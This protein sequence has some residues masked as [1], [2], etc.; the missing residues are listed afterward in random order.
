[1]QQYQPNMNETGG[2]TPAP[3]KKRSLRWNAN[4]LGGIMLGNI[5]VNGVITGVIM[6]VMLFMNWD[7]SQGLSFDTQ[8]SA[9]TLIILS[10]IGSFAGNG[11]LMGIVYLIRRK[12][13]NVTFNRGNIVKILPLCALLLLAVNLMVSSTDYAIT[14]LLDFDVSGDVSA[15]LGDGSFLTML[16]CVGIAAP[17]IE[18]FAFR[19]VIFSLFREYGFCVAAVVSAAMF[20]LMH[21]NFTQFAFTFFAGL[22]FA[23]AYERSGKLIYPILLHMLNNCYGVMESFYPLPAWVS[24]GLN[25]A[26][27]AFFAVRAILFIRKKRTLSQLFDCTGGESKKL[28]QFFR[29]PLVIIYAAL[30]VLAGIF[31]LFSGSLMKMIS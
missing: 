8:L 23:Y 25:L 21:Q 18:E 24:I 30:C 2:D 10:I 9:D 4:F 6:A 16:I 12:S 22:I 5:E 7:I 17:I 19:K 13:L 15:M 26:L 31:T 28:G 29:Q 20:S 1:M 3:I 11:I 27:L 14:K